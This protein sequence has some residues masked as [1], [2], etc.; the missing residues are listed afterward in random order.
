MKFTVL[1]PPSAEDLR[2][3]RIHEL[4]RDYPE[5]VKPLEGLGI[6]L[7]AAGGKTLPSVLQESAETWVPRLLDEVRWRGEGN[8]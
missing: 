5:L 7:G 8:V 3:R 1:P 6:D 2:T 4:A